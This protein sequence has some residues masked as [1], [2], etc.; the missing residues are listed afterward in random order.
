MLWKTYFYK[1][2]RGEE[3]VKEFIIELEPKTQGKALSYIDMLKEHGPLLGM[4]YAKKITTE[5][6]ELRLRGKLEVRIFYGFI[7]NEICL[8]HAFKK[9]TNKTPTQE[10][11]LAQNRF[12]S[13]TEV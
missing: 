6:Y 12:R 10:I 3:L 11:E 1:T 4:P 2:N 7:G 13:L 8:L 9:Q 5:I